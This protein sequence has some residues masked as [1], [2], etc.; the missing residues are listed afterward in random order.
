MS[1]NRFVIKLLA[2]TVE[3]LR[4]DKNRLDNTFQYLWTDSNT[5]ADAL[6]THD[7]VMIK[8]SATT[9]REGTEHDE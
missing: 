9:C 3:K 1:G 5:R 8:D 4:R 6:A 2:E 7:G